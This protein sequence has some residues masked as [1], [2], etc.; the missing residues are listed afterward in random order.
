MGSQLLDVTHKHPSSFW[1]FTDN[2]L[3]FLRETAL[4]AGYG[5]DNPSRE[6][7]NLVCILPVPSSA[8][9]F[10][11]LTDPRVLRN[12]TIGRLHI[13]TSKRVYEFGVEAGQD[14]E[15]HAELTVLNNAFSVHLCTMGSLGFT[16]MEYD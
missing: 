5:P 9:S 8:Y 12:I 13:I 15:P 7:S 4:T 3:T 14:V 11:I 1:S 2:S 16:V 6:G 10:F